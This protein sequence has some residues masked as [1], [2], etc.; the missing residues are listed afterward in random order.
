M[1]SGLWI[2]SAIV[3]IWTNSM[4][5]RYTSRD[6]YDADYGIIEKTEN[7]FY[8]IT[9]VKTK[10]QGSNSNYLSVGK[11]I[12]DVDDFGEEITIWEH[13]DYPNKF[14]DV[15]DF[16]CKRIFEGKGSR[17]S[18]T[19]YLLIPQKFIIEGFRVALIGTGVGGKGHHSTDIEVFFDKARIERESLSL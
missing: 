10:P 18:I 3:V 1:F 4:T 19:W 6:I 2:L 15:E 7:G 8:K 17:S 12:K 5:K 13:Y 14:D 11:F 16:K 9:G